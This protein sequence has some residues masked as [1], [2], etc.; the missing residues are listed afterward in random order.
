MASWSNF[1][2]FRPKFRPNRT[3][4]VQK[5]EGFGIFQGQKIQII[6]TKIF[7]IFL[8]FRKIENSKLSKNHEK[9]TLKSKFGNLGKLVQTR[10]LTQKFG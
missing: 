9:M 1:K 8:R 3:K 7:V 6:F 5:L 2:L 4:N 10:K